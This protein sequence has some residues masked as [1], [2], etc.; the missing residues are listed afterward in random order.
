MVRFVDVSDLVPTIPKKRI[1]V[2]VLRRY[3]GYYDTCRTDQQGS[4]CWIFRKTHIGQ[5]VCNKATPHLFEIPLKTSTSIRKWRALKPK[6]FFAFVRFEDVLDGLVNPVFGVDLI[7]RVMSV[8]NYDEDVSP[9]ITWNQVY[10]ELETENVDYQANIHVNSLMVG[11]CVDNIICVLRFAKLEMAQDQWRATT[12]GA[13]TKLLF[14][15][16]CPE[17]AAMRTYFAGRDDGL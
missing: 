12:A 9:D 1:R 3:D 16:I 10:L 5:M 4:S 7:G 11:R 8:G 14:N 2:K 17:E 13:C 15:P 6:H